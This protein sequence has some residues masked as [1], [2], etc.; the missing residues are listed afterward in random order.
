MCVEFR[1]VVTSTIEEVNHFPDCVRVTARS[2]AEPRSQKISG[3][4]VR[5]CAKVSKVQP[6]AGVYEANL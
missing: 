2:E 1:S 6:S 5:A 4:A 3:I